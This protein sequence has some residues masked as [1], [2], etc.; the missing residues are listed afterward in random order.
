MS[1]PDPHPRGLI[2]PAHLWSPVSPPSSGAIAP[3]GPH[4]RNKD[5]RL[6]AVS[7]VVLY[8][9]KCKVCQSASI[10]PCGSPDVLQIKKRD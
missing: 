8:T 10:H 4:L 2:G 6:A 3:N 1:V 5:D 7:H 9:C